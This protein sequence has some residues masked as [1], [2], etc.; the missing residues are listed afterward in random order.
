MADILNTVL[1][2]SKKNPVVR[3]ILES[4][5]DQQKPT[6]IFLYFYY[7]G[8]RLKYSTGQKVAPADWDTEKQRANTKKKAFYFDVNNDL[9]KIETLTYDIYRE[10]NRGNIAPADFRLEIDYR[11]GFAGRPEDDTPFPQTFLEFVNEFYEERAGQPNAIDGSLQVLRK[12]KGHL[13]QYAKEKRNRLTFSEIDA[14]FFQNFKA[15]LHSPPRSFSTNYV[16][17]IF[18]NVKMFMREAERRGR[19]SNKAYENFKV[20]KAPTTKIRLT[21]SE[22]DHLYRMDLSENP[23]LEKVR[24]LF[25]IGAYTG[26]RFSDFVRISPEHIKEQDG[27]KLLELTTKKTG[28]MVNIPLFP[29]LEK[30]LEKYGNYAPQISNQKMNAYLKELGELAGLNEVIKKIN[31]IGGKRNETTVKR[32]TLLTTHVARRSFATNFYEKYPNFI[33]AIM[34]I[35][36]H[37]TERAFR[38]Y[39]C[40]DAKK[41]AVNFAEMVVLSLPDEDP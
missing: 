18:Q 17:K 34:Q 19:H 35:T 15:W 37:S 38:E 10:T 4:T 36:G 6:Y 25:L 8:Q 21:F 20:K 1:A 41:S 24:D 2:M 5:K 28:Q 23:K 39:I 31:T 12:V 30:I 27:Q 16:Q 9:S 11:M 29:T 14:T 13:T 7:R 26:L 22:L 33:Y 40:I 3:F 32:H